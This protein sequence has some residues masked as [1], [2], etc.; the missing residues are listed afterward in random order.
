V[1]RLL[2]LCLT[3]NYFD[4]ST[5]GIDVLFD[6]KGRGYLVDINPRVTGSC[7][8]LMTLYL[9]KKKYGFQVGLFR[10]SGNITFR[11]TADELWK[12]VKAY[13]DENEGNSRIVIH[14]MYEASEGDYCRINMGVYGNDMDDCKKVLNRFAKPSPEKH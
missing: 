8:A 6:S 5:P 12:Q 1:R 10:R 4:Q 11:G 14:S 7:P 2:S 13:N 9:F 3:C